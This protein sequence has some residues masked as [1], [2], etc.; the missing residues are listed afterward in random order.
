[1]TL[2]ALLVPAAASFAAVSITKR[3]VV[4]SSRGASAIVERDPFEL[5]IAARSGAPVLS[6]VPNR[7]PGPATVPPTT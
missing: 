2:L 3:R 5:R 1:M 6:E 7:R 4:V